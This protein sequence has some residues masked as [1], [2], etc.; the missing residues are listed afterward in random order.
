M[1]EGAEIGRRTSRG[2]GWGEDEDKGE[3]E[4]WEKKWYEKTKVKEEAHDVY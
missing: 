4:D 3:Y 1:A 2:G